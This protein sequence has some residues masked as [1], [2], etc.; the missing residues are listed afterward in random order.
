[1]F[2]DWPNNFRQQGL[3]QSVLLCL[4][5]SDQNPGQS[6]NEIASLEDLDSK[7]T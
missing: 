5:I 2:G 1:M 3:I 6:L 7:K 4:S